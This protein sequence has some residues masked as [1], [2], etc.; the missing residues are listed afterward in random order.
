MQIFLKKRFIVFREFDTWGGG[1]NV[2]EV[3]DPKVQI[4]WGTL[5]R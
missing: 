4:L 5:L 2:N 1:Y 3:F